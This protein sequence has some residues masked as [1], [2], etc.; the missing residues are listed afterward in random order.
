MLK[1]NLY[2]IQNIVFSDQLLQVTVE[3]NVDHP[4]F[5]G[6]FPDVPV[7]PG[8]SMMQMVK[9]LMEE[10][11]GERLRIRKV[12]SMKFLQMINPEKN[13]ILKVEV[14]VIEKTEEIIRI[15]AQMMIEE[16][17]CFKMI[18]HLSIV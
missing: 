5:E 18:A 14:K 13:S 8:V 7:L 9:E 10:Q 11:E 6:H 2:T 17:I 4:I 12:S 3:L 16:A 1:G 15:K